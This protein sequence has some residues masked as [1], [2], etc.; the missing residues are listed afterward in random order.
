M[1]IELKKA[2]ITAIHKAA[3]DYYDG[4]K[5]DGSDMQECA[6]MVMSELIGE[7][8]MV[9]HSMGLTVEQF[10]QLVD[11]VFGDIEIV[12]QKVLEENR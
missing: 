9:A 2:A 8:A 4:L 12:A 10:H 3:T 1:N 5:A 7:A 11:A 6:V